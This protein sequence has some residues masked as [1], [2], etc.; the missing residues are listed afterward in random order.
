MC[1]PRMVENGLKSAFAHVG[2]CALLVYN[3]CLTTKAVR[4]T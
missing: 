1:V 2:S 3:L 4:W